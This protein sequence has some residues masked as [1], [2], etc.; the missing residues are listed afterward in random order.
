[1]LACVGLKRE[2]YLY[3]KWNYSGGGDVWLRRIEPD[4]N[5][6]G[7]D[8]EYIDGFFNGRNELFDIIHIV[9]NAKRNSHGSFY[10]ERIH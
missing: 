4:I 7:G 6:F 10:V 2:Q 1:M 8:L 9:V 3:G 5:I